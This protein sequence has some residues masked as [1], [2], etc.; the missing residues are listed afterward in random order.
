M[1]RNRVHIGD[2]MRVGQ[3]LVPVIAN[4]GDITPRHHFAGSFPKELRPRLRV[5]YRYRNQRISVNVVLRY[6]PGRYPDV[7]NPHELIL[8]NKVVAGLAMGRYGGFV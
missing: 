4:N 5:L 7:Q 3:L 8:E 2:A 1:K 6:T